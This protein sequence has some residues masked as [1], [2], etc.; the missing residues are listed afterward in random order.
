MST[1]YIPTAANTIPKIIEASKARLADAITIASNVNTSTTETVIAKA[2]L[3]FENKEINIAV[4]TLC[5]HL[6]STG[7]WS[8]VLDVAVLLLID[9][10]IFSDRI[11][12]LQ[13]VMLTYQKVSSHEKTCRF[14]YVTTHV[15][16]R[17]E[18]LM[19]KNNLES[20]V[21]SP[22]ATFLASVLPEATSSIKVGLASATPAVASFVSLYF[23]KYRYTFGTN[24]QTAYLS[25][26]TRML[27]FIVRHKLSSLLMGLSNS[28]RDFAKDLFSRSD[29][30][31]TNTL[32]SAVKNS[33]GAVI[34]L[35]FAILEAAIKLSQWQ[36]VKFSLEEIAVVYRLIEEAV[37]RVNRNNMVTHSNNPT[38]V[39]RHVN[40]IDIAHR[41]FA[42]IADVF[43]KCENWVFHADALRSQFAFAGAEARPALA[44]KAIVAALCTAAD[45]D[46][47]E[48]KAATS[49]FEEETPAM[50]LV[51][52]LGLTRMPT[53]ALVMAEAAESL[54]L[55][56]ANAQVL[57]SIVSEK[58]AVDIA[59]IYKHLAAL[60]A[61]PAFAA[62]DPADTDRYLAA[63]ER[64]LLAYFMESHFQTTA[65][66][67][68]ATFDSVALLYPKKN[69]LIAI[70]TGL[71]ARVD[72]KG[73]VA[74]YNTAELRVRN[75]ISTIG[76]KA[77]K[78]LAL[79][80]AKRRLCPTLAAHS[81]TALE[82][83]NTRLNHRV[84]LG[85]MCVH[86]AA[87]RTSNLVKKELEEARSLREEIERE[88]RERHEALKAANFE[89]QKK[90]VEHAENVQRR[91]KVCE[92]VM[93]RHEGLT[94]PVKLT[95]DGKNFLDRASALL[96]QYRRELDE[97][98]TM[99]L[100]EA[101]YM[102][103]YIRD[104]ER[105][106]REE[107][108]R[109]M[110]DQY[111]KDSEARIE[112]FK[113]QHRRNFDNQMALKARLDAYRSRA[114]EYEEASIAAAAA[115]VKVSK[116]DEQEDLLRL[117]K[118]RLMREMMAQ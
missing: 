3:H 108:E 12:K 101:H 60:K 56:D 34:A 45:S 40:D 70:A 27:E 23:R 10:T 46:D 61:S 58:K 31:A 14:D 103:K 86:K 87:E 92:M 102:E 90:K 109:N 26:M 117:E 85:V 17:L 28:L 52:T 49:F 13:K 38:L 33:S 66:L 53:R 105:P 111:K 104:T 78:M 24:F 83:E 32:E 43:L 11:A 77:S 113:E 8:P 88:E 59:V 16:A 67:P 73:R 84:S 82:R 29:I 64:A 44:T 75:C 4:N 54:P 97:K 81:A 95:E 93:K 19:A 47:G 96:A 55:A 30:S 37:K 6:E 74:N 69:D 2:S 100:R 51:A 35:R 63:L 21:A 116:R 65:A 20:E 9:I 15:L 99:N 94:F 71:E 98:R 1:N 62:A 89:K 80:I 41:R 48:A 112:N 79:P 110:A 18:D 114:A 39:A 118:E 76:T 68:F 5:A 72:M 106:R 57:F 91:K 22:D 42:V 107:L 36:V 25:T 115:A 7:K 50:R